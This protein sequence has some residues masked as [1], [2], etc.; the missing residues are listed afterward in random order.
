MVRYYSYLYWNEELP[1]YQVVALLKEPEDIK[2]IAT[3][4]NSDVYDEHLMNYQYKVIKLYEM[5][6]YPVL[7]EKNSGLYPLRVFMRHEGESD[8]QH[9]EECLNAVENIEDPDYYFLTVECGKKLYRTDLIGRI[10]KEAIYMSS[11]LYK[12]PYE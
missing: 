9:L 3:G 12:H 4:I 2:K 1:I 7:K 5:D 10:I 11:V 6:K 8:L